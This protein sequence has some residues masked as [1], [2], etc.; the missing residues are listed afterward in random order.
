MWHFRLLL[1]SCYLDWVGRHVAH[2]VGAIGV[3]QH[4][5]QSE[6]IPQQAVQLLDVLRGRQRGTQEELRLDPTVICSINS[7]GFSFLIQS[8]YSYNILL[9]FVLNRTQSFLS[10][11]IQPSSVQKAEQYLEAEPVL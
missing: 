6:G 10:T 9:Y 5:H 2:E 8:H 7:S 1:I 11:V 4:G 3:V